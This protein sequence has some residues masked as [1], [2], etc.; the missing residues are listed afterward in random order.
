MRLVLALLLA[1]W[2]TSAEAATKCVNGST[3][4]DA[5]TYAANDGVSSCWQ[6]LG[7]AAWGSTTRSSPN[8]GEALQAGD[9]VN[10]A[11]GTYDYAGTAAHS[12]AFDVLYNPANSGSSGSPIRFACI[13][14]CIITAPD[15]EAPVIGA[16]GRDYIQWYASRA[17]GYAWE[18]P[19]CGENP[20]G[21]D[22]CG[23]GTAAGAPDTGPVVCHTSDWCHFEGLD[24]TATAPITYNDNFP[25][26]RFQDVN[27]GTVKNSSCADFTRDTGGN[28]NQSCVMLYGTQN[29]TIEN[30]QFSTSNSGVFF[31]DTGTT[32]N[33]GGNIVRFNRF[34][35]VREAVVWSQLTAGSTES[36]NDVYQNVITGCTQAFGFIDGPAQGSQSDDVFNNTAYDCST[37][38]ATLD[39]N[40]GTHLGIRFWNNIASTTTLGISSVS[41][42]SAATIINFQHNVY[43]SFTNFYN[44]SD[45]NRTLA[46]FTA[47]YTDQ[48]NTS[49]VGVDADPGFVN[50]ATGDFRLCTAAGVP[51]ASCAGASGI[52]TQGVDALDLDGD[53]STSDNIPAGAYLTGL[54][55]IGIDTS[56]DAPA[57]GTGSATK[58]KLRVGEE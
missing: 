15:W 55:T 58:L 10:V 14:T 34:T 56:G 46:S 2:A 18:I 21:G 43:R 36:G 32:A 54:E 3:G 30:N 52:L 57:P 4:S 11:A 29:V 50:A 12:D 53:S 47:A 13:G 26:F 49:P 7:R 25:A 19:A 41:T 1:L 24:I 27:G 31:K 40:D 45:G 22:D 48:E 28:H 20:A 38:F 5:T 16:T 35:T 39:N 42:M 33:Q 44:G 37:S 8:T 51:H 17:A 9:T 6:T 23:A